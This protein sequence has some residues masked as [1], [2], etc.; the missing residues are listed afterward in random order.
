MAHEIEDDLNNIEG[1]IP[2]RSLVCGRFDD[3]LGTTELIVIAERD[4]SGRETADIEVA[5]RNTVN[6]SAGVLPAEVAFVEA[7]FLLKS[8]SGKLARAASYAKFIEKDAQCD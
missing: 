8:T 2:G 5:V 7:G 3:E 4:D 6:S 1:L